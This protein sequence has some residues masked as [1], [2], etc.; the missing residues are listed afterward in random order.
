MNFDLIGKWA[1]QEDIVKVIWSRS[2]VKI[3]AL[4]SEVSSHTMIV[5][6]QTNDLRKWNTI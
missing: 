6:D 4:Q 5:I 1:K 2:E 3:Q